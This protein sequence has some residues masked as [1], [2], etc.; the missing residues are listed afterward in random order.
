MSV[1]YNLSYSNGTDRNSPIYYEYSECRSAQ[2]CRALG[3]LLVYYAKICYPRYCLSNYTSANTQLR[4]VGASKKQC[5]QTIF[6]LLLGAPCSLP[7]FVAG[8]TPS[9][10]H[11]PLVQGTE[12]LTLAGSDCLDCIPRNE[13][14]RSS[15]CHS[16][17]W[18]RSDVARRNA[19]I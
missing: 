2:I 1:I 3:R 9:S 5:M 7:S 6:I 14:L 11:T 10:V 19:G 8:W 4:Q 17:I 15:G 18:V 12:L 13:T 16:T